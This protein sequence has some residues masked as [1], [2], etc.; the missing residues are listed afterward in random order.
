MIP[1]H[2]IMPVMLA[3]TDIDTAL[4]QGGIYLMKV[5]F[6]IGCILIMI[7]G[8]SMH[9]GNGTGALMSMVGGMIMACAVP[10]M[11]SFMTSAG[12]PDAAVNISSLMPIL[13][14][15]KVWRYL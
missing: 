10:F 9:S 8:Y 15:P 7:G 2:T 4:S 6:L 13:T 12:M 11:K 5:G 1:I 14:H 3:A